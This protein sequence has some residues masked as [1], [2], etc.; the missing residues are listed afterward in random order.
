VTIL[1][2]ILLILAIIIVVPIVVYL[3]MKLGTVGFY[4]GK[5]A[6]HREN[7]FNV[8]DNNKKEN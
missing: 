8:N 2:W 6:I 4:R 7:N 5:E 1:D 3:C